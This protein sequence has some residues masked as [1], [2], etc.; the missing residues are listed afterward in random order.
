MV[1]ISDPENKDEL[2]MECNEET[3]ETHKYI[4]LKDDLKM[5]SGNLFP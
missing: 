1:R 3:S 5:R 2:L 4:L